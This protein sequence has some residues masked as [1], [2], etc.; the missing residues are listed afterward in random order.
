[1]LFTSNP[2]P[3]Y[4]MAIFFFSFPGSEVAVVAESCEVLDDESCEVLDEFVFDAGR[5]KLLLDLRL[6]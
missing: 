6:E 4:D 3:T 5:G 1:M 2:Y